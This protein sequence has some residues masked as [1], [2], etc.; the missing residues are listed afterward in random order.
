MPFLKAPRLCVLEQP[1]ARG[2]R[3]KRDVTGRYFTAAGGCG[4]GK[5][6]GSVAGS[7]GGSEGGAEVEVEGEWRKK[8]MTE[9]RREWRGSA[10]GK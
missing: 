5:W 8:W 2:K 3:G 6:R 10:E 4:V 1:I 9:C 7:G